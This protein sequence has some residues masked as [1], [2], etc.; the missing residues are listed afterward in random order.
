MTNKFSFIKEF[1]KF[2]IKKLNIKDHFN[3]KY[4]EEIYVNEIVNV[5]RSSCYWRRYTG[6]ICGRI[7]NNKH[8]IYVKNGL[9]KEFYKRMLDKYLQKNRTSKLKYQSIDSSFIQNKFGTGKI[10]RNK[11]YKNKKG[12]KLSSIVDVNGIPL[13]IFVDSGNIHDAKLFNPT[14]AN[15]LI[16]TNSRKYK[17]HNR[18]KQYF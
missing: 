9:Y 1:S 14:C 11:Y 16:V 13:S 10:G 7:L 2:A 12:I 6:V 18:Y 5:L 15:M 3:R 8:N 4:S 17:N